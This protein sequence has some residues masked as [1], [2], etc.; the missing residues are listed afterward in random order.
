MQDVKLTVVFD[1]CQDQQEYF[2]DSKQRQARLLRPELL[3]SNTLARALFILSHRPATAP[4]GFSSD[5]LL[6]ELFE[7]EH[8]VDFKLDSIICILS[9]LWS[10]RIQTKPGVCA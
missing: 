6:E 1:Y 8:S 10:T 2:E 3:D 9:A 4:L 5:S 7:N